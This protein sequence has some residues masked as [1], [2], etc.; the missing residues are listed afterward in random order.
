MTQGSDQARRGATMSVYK[1]IE[2][3]GASSP[4]WEDAAV[5]A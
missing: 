4:S 3:V 5:W 2:V 1:I